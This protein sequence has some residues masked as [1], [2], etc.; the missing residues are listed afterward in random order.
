MSFRPVTSFLLLESCPCRV[1]VGLPR[2]TG[3]R[4]TLT[5]DPTEPPR[6]QALLHASLLQLG[7]SEG[8]MLRVPFMRFVKYGVLFCV[9]LLTNVGRRLFRGRRPSRG[10]GA[11]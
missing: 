9:R 3:F 11:R 10:M 5:L 4:L 7:M 1:V 8:L 6:F 2:R